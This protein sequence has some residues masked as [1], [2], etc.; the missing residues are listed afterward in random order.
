[1]NSTIIYAATYVNIIIISA[2]LP[3]TQLQSSS[4]SLGALGQLCMAQ[5]GA[6]VK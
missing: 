5:R 1:M 6:G 4:S 2:E 3:M